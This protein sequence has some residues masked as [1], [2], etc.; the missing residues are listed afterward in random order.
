MALR[1][2]LGTVTGASA[3]TCVIVLG[4]VSPALADRGFAAR[5]STNAS[6]DI[7]VI[8]NTLESCQSSAADC[9]SA[10]SGKGAALNNNNFAMERVDVD[11]AMFDSSS[12][13]LNL[14]AGARV[15]FAGLYYGARTT[16]GTRGK[17]ALDD[18]RSALRTVELKMPGA[19]RYERVVG[20]LDEST[21]VN[22]A[23]GVFVDVTRQVRQGGS[24]AYTVANVQSATGEDRY[25]G[26]ALVV[27]FEAA[28]DPPRNLTVFDGLQS[29]TQ[30]KP[31]LTIPVSGFQTPLSGPVGTKLGF[32]AYE[33]D[34]GATGDSA[35]LDGKALSDAL[36]PANNFFNSMISVDV[37]HVTR[38]DPGYVNQLGFDAKL[39]GI[40]GILA[41]G[42]TS[43]DIAL[44]TSGD[45]YLPHAITFA[46]DL[47]APAIHATKTVANLTRPDRP[48]HAGD[49]LRYTVHF[50]NE[51]LEA[52]RN[53][54]AEDALPAGI[55]YL[56]G[57]M[58]IPGAPGDAARP[59]DI[60]GDD[61]GEYDGSA[62]GVRFFLGAGAAPGR[63]GELAAAGRPGDQTEVSFEARVNENMSSAREI[64]DVAQASFLA[65]SLN[66][67]LSALSSPATVNVIPGPPASPPADLAIEQTETAAADSGGSDVVDDHILL[68]NHGPGDATDVV[69]HEKLPPGATVE[70][71]ASDQGS[72]TVSAGG[73]TCTVP[74]LDAG[75]SVE[76]NIVVREPAGD[77]T[78]GSIDEATVTASQFDPTPGNNSGEVTVPQPPSPGVSP[79][80]ADVGVRLHESAATAPLGGKLTD[81]ITVTNHG[82]AAATGADLTD[83]L[84]AAT[85]LIA[86]HPGRA[87]CSPSVPLHCTLATLAPGASLTIE[88]MLRPLRP[89]RLIDAASVSAGQ[90]DANV[91]NNLA[92]VS[93]TVRRR[94]TAARLRIL[95]V[96]PVAN[97]GHVVSFVIV[98]ALTR[99]TPGVT[100][101]VC[102]TLAARL[103]LTAAPA[104][105]TDGT[106]VCW[107]VID[108]VAGHP[109]NFQLRARI[110][111]A[112]TSGATL[113]VHGR[114]TGENFGVT[115]AAASVQVPRRAV[116][117]PSRV[118][119]TPRA[120]IAC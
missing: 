83:V 120:R 13:D 114:L 27:A 34:L 94:T 63:G 80:V 7:A 25:A 55:T 35:A 53:F 17:A 87:S 78:S 62:R 48:A 3:M 5:F 90:V 15:L 102:V 16:A 22:G 58:R 64:T 66:K 109:R 105:T 8:G 60:Q 19:A 20:E 108:L 33:G 118:L 12:A 82:P 67:E 93:T 113:A 43:A 65:P 23:Y 54:V 10:R 21:Q 99:P 42:A 9:G 91:A 92:K 89:G 28:G 29:V 59:S 103:H 45:Q 115:R 106:Q 36:N 38:K 6:G 40:N 18:T 2:G 111:A 116:A 26:W 88:L 31:A 57:S 73:V 112:H 44:R 71:V 85:E 56:T 84:G 52:A 24:G 107:R 81:T 46:T 110:A 49:T 70:S 41:N 96:Q 77:A 72:C 98:A 117:C 69:L 14:P 76:I 101:M 104:A 1:R 50:T 4:L 39:I 97:A 100:P 86:V 37:R 74:D 61:L 75:G 79:P 51:G 47:Y 119:V 32:V 30:G 95:P 68:E 11:H